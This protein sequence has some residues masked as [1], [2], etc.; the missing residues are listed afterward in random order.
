[1]IST[2]RHLGYLV[3]INIC[4]FLFG[5]LD[6]ISP[7]ILVD[8]FTIWV[9]APCDIHEI[10]NN[11]EWAVLQAIEER[12]LKEHVFCIGKLMNGETLIHKGDQALVM[13]VHEVDIIRNNGIVVPLVE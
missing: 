9:F 13:E 12:K 2:Y 5:D 1:M 4:S 10:C 8:H 3:T 6:N 11:G 7:L